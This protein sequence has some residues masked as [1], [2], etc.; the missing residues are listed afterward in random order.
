MTLTE[1]DLDLLVRDRA[2]RLLVL[3]SGKRIWEASPSPL[4]Q[5]LVVLEVTQAR[6]VQSLKELGKPAEVLR[7]RKERLLAA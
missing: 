4:H 7:D 6:G 3:G 1:H 2:V 5:M